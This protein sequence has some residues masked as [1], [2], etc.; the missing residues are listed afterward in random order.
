[1]ERLKDKVAIV[2][3]GTSGIG[4]ACAVAFSREGAHVVVA[5]R[6]RDTGS[7]L[8]D[9]LGGTGVQVASQSLTVA[10][11]AWGQAIWAP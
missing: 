8:A 2:T 9:S 6:R 5:G 10:L 11:P 1:M 4:R 3:G 7:A